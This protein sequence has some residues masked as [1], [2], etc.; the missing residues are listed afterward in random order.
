MLIAL[1][2][3]EESIVNY[4][5]YQTTLI[6]RILDTAREGTGVYTFKSTGFNLTKGYMVFMRKIANK[7]V[8]L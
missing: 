5:L 2:Q 1:D 4:F 8:D 6:K 7:I 3:N